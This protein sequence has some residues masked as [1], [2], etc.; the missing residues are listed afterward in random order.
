MVFNRE[1]KEK[2]IPWH[3][4][5]KEIPE[6]NVFNRIGTARIS[7]LISLEVNCIDCIII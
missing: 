2:G 6:T 7:W 3:M 1:K 5:Y 4:P